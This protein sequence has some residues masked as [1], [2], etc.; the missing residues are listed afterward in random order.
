MYLKKR[1]RY[2]LNIFIQIKKKKTTNQHTNKKTKTQH[3]NPTN[4]PSMKTSSF[5]PK[6]LFRLL[7]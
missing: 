2:V 7:S 5:L 4:K 3:K 1:Q 6:I